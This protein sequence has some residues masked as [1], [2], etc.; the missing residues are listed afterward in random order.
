MVKN[1]GESRF[2]LLLQTVFGVD[3]IINKL[4]L[5]FGHVSFGHDVRVGGGLI[6]GHLVSIFLVQ[7]ADSSA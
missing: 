2:Y 5:R 3:V 6:S 4:T 7:N 1:I